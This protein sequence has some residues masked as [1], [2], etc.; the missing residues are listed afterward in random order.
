MVEPFQEDEETGNTH[1]STLPG[2]WFPVEEN[3]EFHAFQII[4]EQEVAE[5]R[6]RVEYYHRDDQ[7]KETQENMNIISIT[8]EIIDDLLTDIVGK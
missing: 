1:S 7:I 5:E 8:G 2:C 4:D 3:T 6:Q